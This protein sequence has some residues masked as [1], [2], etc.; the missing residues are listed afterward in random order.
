MSARFSPPQIELLRRRAKKLRRTDSLLS[1]SDALNQVAHDNGWANWALLVKN[2]LPSAEDLITLTCRQFPGGMKGVLLADMTI[3]NKELQKAINS[4]SPSFE[5]PRHNGWFFR[6]AGPRQHEFTPFI[7][8]RHGTPRGV[9]VNGKWRAILSINGIQ[10]S[11]I[12]THMAATLPS[13]LRDLKVSAFTSLLP[14]IAGTARTA[15]GHVRLFCSKPG[16]N[17]IATISERAYASV[18]EAKTAELPD[19]WVRIGIPLN[20]GTWLTY[21]E[22]FGWSA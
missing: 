18:T 17:G 4:G 13:V 3:A 16:D 6:G 14:Y 5:L 7:D 8:L 15:D 21:Q 9:F 19:G 22:P 11:Q 20:D 1:Q 10:E 2:S 12:Q